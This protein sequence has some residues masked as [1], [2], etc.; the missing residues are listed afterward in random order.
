MKLV[1]KGR[2]SFTSVKIF[3]KFKN[4]AR[5]AKASERELLKAFD[6]TKNKKEQKMKKK[7][8]KNKRI[9]K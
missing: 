1:I 2:K 4:N 7:S 6:D 3:S 5:T 8:D 9:S